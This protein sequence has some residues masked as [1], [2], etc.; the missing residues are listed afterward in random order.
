MNKNPIK[1]T[2]I[3]IIL[4]LVY[5]INA[6]S[7][8]ED[9]IL[10]YVE[11]D[12]IVSVVGKRGQMSF[13]NIPERVQ[14]GSK[15]YT[16]VEIAETAFK[17]CTDIV[18][19]S[20]PK[21]IRFVGL[22]AFEGCTSLEKVIVS[23]IAAFCN[24]EFEK[25]DDS[26]GNP[27][28]L[29]HHLYKDENTEYTEL[30]IPET[31]KSIPWWQFEG[32]YS[33]TSIV[34]PNTVTSIGSGAFS[35][36]KNVKSIV[37]GNSLTIIPPFAFR[38]CS[39]LEN[40]EIPNSIQKIGLAAF[41][42]CVKLSSLV[43]PSSLTSFEYTEHGY[44][45]SNGGAF[46]NCSHLSYVRSDIATPFNISSSIFKNISSSAILKVPNGSKEKYEVLSG[47]T[48]NF[49]EIVEDTPNTYILSVTTTGNGTASYNGTTI[50]GKTS[51]FTVEEGTSATITFTPDNGYRIKSV[52]FNNTDVT[53]DVSDNSY[54]ISSI[55]G[56]TSVEVEFE[57][58]PSNIS[59]ADPNVKSLCVA[60][61]DVD[62]DGELSEAEAA[63]I[64]DLGTVFSG[65]TS[66][67]SFEELEYFTGLQTISSSAF[68]GC[69]KLEKISFPAFI[70][71]IEDEA[72]S[73]CIKLTGSL[74]IPNSVTSIGT[75]AFRGCSGFT[76]SLTIPNSV[77]SIEEWTFGGCKGLTGDLII[78]N[79]VT[80]IGTSAFQGCSGFTGSLTLSN[81]LKT[82]G[83]GAFYECCGLTGTLTIP[84][85]VTSIGPS[86]FSGCK[87]FDGSLTIP[88]SVTYIGHSAFARCSGLIGSLTIPNS[89]TSLG[90]NAF[91]NCSGLT[92]ELSISNN[93]VKIDEYTFSGCSGLTGSLTIP[94]SV[95]SIGT[96]AFQDCSGFT[97]SLTIPNSVTSIGNSAFAGCSKLTGDLIIPNSVKTI[98]Q[99]A[100]S[101]C[102][103]LTGILT[104]PN[105]IV[106]IGGS[107]FAYCGFTGTLT[108]PNSLTSINKYAFA[109]CNNL[110]VVII[111]NSVTSIGEGAFQYCNNLI[112]V[113]SEIEEPFAIDNSV[114]QHNASIDY[115]LKI[116]EGTR[117][118]YLEYNGWTTNFTRILED[119]EVTLTIKA[120]GNGSAIYDETTIRENSNSFIVVKGTSV[121]VNFTSDTGC[122]IKSV[123][124]NNTDVS[125]S[126]VNNQ[127]T[128]FDIKDD[129]TLEVEF[130]P[131]PYT[132]TIKSVGNGMASYEGSEVRNQT[133]YF[134]VTGGSSVT[135]AFVSDN[136]YRIKGVKVDDVDVTGA[137]V[138]SQYTISNISKDVSLEVEF[139]EI[140][141]A[142]CTLSITSKGYGSANYDDTTVR[143][144]TSI[145]T[146]TAGTSALVDFVPDDGYRILSV[147][148]N[149]ADIT[150]NVFN[151]Q[152]TIV[153]ITHDTALEVEFA[154]NVTDITHNGVNYN[155]ASFIDATLNVAAGD[156]GLTISVPATLSFKNRQW[157]VIGVEANAFNNCS[158][159]AAIEWNPEAKFTASVNNPNLLLFVKDE[160]YASEAI[161][162]VVVNGEAEEIVLQE[163]ESGN[164]FYCPKAFTAKKIIFEHNY[165]MKSGY[166]TCQGWESIA[167]PFDVTKIQRLG[168]TELLPYQAW[169]QGSSQRP[170]WLYSLTELGWKAESSITANTPY[171]ISMPNNEMYN[172][173]YNISGI[174]QFIG[175]N[176][177]VKASDNLSY[178]KEGSKK[179]IPNFQNQEAS[180]NFFVLNVNNQW[181]SNTDDAVEGSAFIR[182]LRQV[183]PFEAYMTSDS[184][185]ASRIIPVF[186]DIEDMTGI[187]GILFA[188]DE[189]RDVKVY[190][191]EGQ[192]VAIGKRSELMNKLP[193]GIFVI[194]GR[195]VVVK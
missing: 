71:S 54:T 147:K 138:N 80:S 59:F 36:C 155:V 193:K 34:L 188:N 182:G 10:Y 120:T 19:V 185:A 158:K 169:T 106:S 152:Y 17:N 150:P 133:S 132:I 123:K 97:G 119:G 167:L 177:Q 194:D 63:A 3:S 141:P 103:S 18:S 90:N 52:K 180:Q 11:G 37:L 47:W 83:D 136:G 184:N 27:L 20:I 98:G 43:L 122:K 72:F 8:E 151:N 172:S 178:G 14:L 156:Y 183:R 5:T 7:S 85:S 13:L 153:N 6:Y 41:K 91:Q 56:D 113:E 135:I 187:Y 121:I 173:S 100:F 68:K 101:S 66:I 181:N 65:N 57:L 109:N 115:V 40:F 26:Y 48:V 78:P 55:A 89:V 9:G 23:D 163:A 22:D 42:G 82:I 131:I 130:E 186:E 191:I 61:W 175:E 32:C 75:S 189:S 114:F 35:G 64:T 164:N 176:V 87:G 16:V 1:R 24:I 31:V 126:V 118:K 94:N 166:N 38:D 143:S 112:L 99:L 92:G 162:N 51:T 104:L 108:I 62:G 86:A 170:F 149:G 53:S 12:N 28:G 96:S 190:T 49:S 76:G 145:F 154:E 81:S 142:V 129:N 157:K 33:F 77:K 174:V 168:G 84:N 73:G 137:V 44:G 192:L 128:I 95:T 60:N 117:S 88:S 116:P 134:S 139:E 127:Y 74:T 79:S 161:Q 171:I 160:Q 102:S 105:T 45:E 93:I 144:K 124:L 25:A 2:I 125:T 4:L 67:I 29:A 15:T 30:V 195:K 179:L 46:E 159:L 39:S 21:T 69:N 111:S 165:S 58:I 140:P 148:L 146:V 107:A 110:A 50:R 70:T